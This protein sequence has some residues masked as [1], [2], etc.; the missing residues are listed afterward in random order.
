MNLQF[1][2]Y[3]GAGNDF[4]IIDNRTN[5]FAP[6]IENVKYLCNRRIGIGA[7]G[8]ML[9]ENDEALDFKMRY[10]NSDGNE[11]TMCGNGGRCI[12]HFAKQLNLTNDNPKF[13][14]IDGA[15]EAKFIDD[16]TVQLKMK[17]VDSFTAA[18]DYYFID[19][20]SPHYIC[21][22]E[23]IK[24]VNVNEAGKSIRTTFN[25][26][27]GGTN[28]NF[29][30]IGNDTLL[31]RTFERGVEEETLACGTGAV[32][33]AIATHHFL[34]SEEKELKLQALGGELTVSFDKLAELKYSNI[35]L[36]GPV[37]HVFNGIVNL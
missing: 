2:K 24:Q 31:I 28:V 32:A 12:V 7:D 10:F 1:A 20:G 13:M 9:L 37:K 6:T 36:T 5:T 27:N 35:W 19:T 17:D 29:V 3:H 8:L 26:E 30:Q 33:S 23:D 22:V 4:V 11:S 18:D 16:D 15:H 21:Y 34:E 25:T 14:G